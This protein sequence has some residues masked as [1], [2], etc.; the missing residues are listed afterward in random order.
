M[1]LPVLEVDVAHEAVGILRCDWF[2]K[3][4][5][6]KVG[7]RMIRLIPRIDAHMISCFVLLGK[8]ALG[9]YREIEYLSI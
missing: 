6:G 7:M 3:G 5:V 9:E 4:G 2:S 8:K 1:V